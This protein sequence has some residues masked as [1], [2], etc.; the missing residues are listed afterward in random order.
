MKAETFL[1]ILFF[2]GGLAVGTHIQE[3]VTVETIHTEYVHLP[4]TLSDWQLTQ[5][6]IA[7][8][9]SRFNP[10]ALGKASDSGLL[11]LTPIYVAEVNRI[12]GA[13]YILD[14]A[15]DIGKSLEM[16]D[17]MQ[18]HYNPERDIDTAIYYHNKSPYYRKEVK[19]NLEF[20][21]RYETARAAIMK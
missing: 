16:F 21:Q 6:A 10:D 3:P 5:M 15:F 8:T 7:M 14:D 12:S 17:R 19:R 2:A 9:E 4:D 20:I 13:D 18:A 11:Q 1:I